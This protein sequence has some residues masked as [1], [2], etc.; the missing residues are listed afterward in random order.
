MHGSFQGTTYLDE[1]TGAGAAAPKVLTLNLAATGQVG[2]PAGAVTPLERTH[3]RE[4]H[5]PGKP[6]HE[7]PSAG[8]A[9]ELREGANR[10]AFT[11]QTWKAH[12]TG[13]IDFDLYIAGDAPMQA[14]IGNWAHLWHPGTEEGEFRA[15]NQCQRFE[16]RQLRPTREPSVRRGPGRRRH[17]ATG[18]TV[19]Q[20]GSERR[21]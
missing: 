12:S 18:D 16:E 10:L 21:V 6:D 13:G 8:K 17:R 14:H 9:L 15:A 7:L 3:A 19:S 5:S 2:T 11:G 20:C 1:F 4:S